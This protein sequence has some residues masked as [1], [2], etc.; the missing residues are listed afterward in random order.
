M[1]ASDTYVK[2]EEWKKGRAKNG[3]P[4]LRADSELVRRIDGLQPF[5]RL[6]DPQVHPLARLVLH[7]NHAKHRTP[8]ITAVRLAAMYQDDQM[9]RSMLDLPPQPEEPLRVGDVIAETPVGTQVPVTVFPTIGINRPGTNKWPVLMRELEEIS[10]WVRFQAVPRLV[11]GTEPPD[12][13]LPARYV[14]AVG[15]EDER[16][17]IAAGSTTSAADRHKQ[18]LGAASVRVDLVETIGETDG[19][20]SA[21]TIAAWLAHL[22]DEEVLARMLRLQVTHTYDRDVMRRNVKVLEGFRDEALRFGHEDR[23]AGK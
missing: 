20:P 22:T 12:P 14:I 11:T 8:A 15:H 16:R 1:P 13:A 6:R 7:T 5:H 10:Y 9:P 19:S 2:F 17:A 3:P 23:A 4:S 18:R 21:G